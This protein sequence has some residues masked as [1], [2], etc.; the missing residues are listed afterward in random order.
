MWLLTLAAR[1]PRQVARHHI[2]KQRYKHQTHGDP[3]TPIMMRMFP[4]RTMEAMRNTFA[5]R[6]IL[7]VV[8]V[9]YLIH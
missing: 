2:G 7:L 6:T 1:A 9:L 8:T 3:Q 4:V 5:I